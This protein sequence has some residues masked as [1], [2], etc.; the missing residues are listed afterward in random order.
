MTIFAYQNICLQPDASDESDHAWRTDWRCE[1][2]HVLY[3]FRVGTQVLGQFP[4]P[5][6]KDRWAPGSQDAINYW[7]LVTFRRHS[8]P[9][10]TAR[11][12]LGCKMEGR[13]LAYIQ[14][15]RQVLEILKR[16]DDSILAIF[17]LRAG[18]SVR[19]Q[20]RMRQLDFALL[21]HASN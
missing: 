20:V 13:A 18:D 11:H 5:I 8:C 3:P 2:P 10:R 12:L 17:L 16:L 1:C 4:W 7:P 9:S 21:E 19:N 6:Y 15:C 14:N